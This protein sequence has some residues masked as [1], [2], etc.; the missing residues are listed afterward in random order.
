MLNN[1]KRIFSDEYIDYETYKKR[2]DMISV[3]CRQQSV[4]KQDLGDIYKQI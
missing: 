3:F 4:R 2:M 1:L